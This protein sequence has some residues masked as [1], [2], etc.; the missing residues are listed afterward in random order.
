M[1]SEELSEWRAADHLG[2]VP[3]PRWLAGLIAATVLNSASGGKARSSPDD[4]M[5]RL[6]PAAQTPQEMMSALRAV[7]P[8]T[9]QGV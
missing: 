4:F 3:D 9:T 8:V 6:R 5:P 1:D 7:R 2:L